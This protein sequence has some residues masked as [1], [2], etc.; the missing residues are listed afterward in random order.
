MTQVNF[1]AVVTVPVSYQDKPEDF[2][3]HLTFV[4]G[5]LTE[6]ANVVSAVWNSDSQDGSWVITLFQAN[7]PI[8]QDMMD[9]MVPVLEYLIKDSNEKHID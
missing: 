7:R 6:V 8:T 4:Y 1:L 3:D 9:A 2:D 5:R